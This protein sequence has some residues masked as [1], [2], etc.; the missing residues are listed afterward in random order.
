M[1]EFKL[2]S[3]TASDFNKK[4]NCT[5]IYVTML[6]I[7]VLPKMKPLALS[8][9]RNLEQENNEIVRTRANVP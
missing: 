9:S 5:C 4:Y 2:P 7:F 6:Q 8:H 1:K 3:K